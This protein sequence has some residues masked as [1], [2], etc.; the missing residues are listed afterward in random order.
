MKTERRPNAFTLIEVLIVV[1]I[2]AV[3]AATIIPQFS[4]STKDAQQSSV[5]FNAHTLRQQIELYKAHHVGNYPKFENNSI[6]QLIKATDVNGD[7]N[8]D[9]KPDSTHPFGPYMDE[10]PSNPFNNLKTVKEVTT[11]G[12]PPTSGDGTTGWQYDAT[13]G[14]I[15]P[16]HK[17]WKP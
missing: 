9:G 6:P 4:S 16:N 15:W 14:G 5:K 2:M 13:T 3:L 8:S 11:A 1:V 12:T 7:S 10:L 17:D